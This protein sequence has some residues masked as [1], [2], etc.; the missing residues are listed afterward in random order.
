MDKNFEK[1]L[2][3]FVEE[4]KKR[5]IDFRRIFFLVEEFEK[6]GLDFEFFLEII[7]ENKDLA[8]KLFEFVKAKLQPDSIYL[9]HWQK[10]YKEWF[11]VDI[12]INIFGLKIPKNYD[13]EKHF[14]VLVA[15]GVTINIIVSAMRKR[16]NVYLY[17]E[18]LDASVTKNDRIPND[19]YFV[20]FNKNIEADKDFKNISAD[21]LVGQEHKGITLLERLLLE[22][23]CYNETNE[24]LDIENVTLCSGSRDSFGSVPGVGWH[25][26][27]NRLGI[28]WY[29]ADICHAG[30][31]SRSAVF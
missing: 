27:F 30:L 17:A 19:T 15:K 12:D 21:D 10:I 9:S 29:G 6:Q 16:F 31:R 13:P 22:V 20:L 2:Y 11:D 24:H 3:S 8:K 18:C 25:S 7:K 26:S 4:L 23:F 28:H 1:D 5:G 14:L